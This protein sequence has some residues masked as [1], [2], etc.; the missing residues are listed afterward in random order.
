[1]NRL[2]RCFLGG[3]ATIG[4]VSLGVVVLSLVF[5]GD[6]RGG[7]AS[8]PIGGRS[9]VPYDRCD[10]EGSPLTTTIGGAGVVFVSAATYFLSGRAGCDGGAAGS[11]F[12]YCPFGAICDGVALVMLTSPETTDVGWDGFAGG[13][14]GTWETG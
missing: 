1:M 10:S 3:L 11:R 13:G 12:G 4:M 6:A 5:M 2:L 14:G 8:F 9:G 7:V